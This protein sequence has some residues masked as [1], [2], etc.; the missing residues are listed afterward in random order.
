MLI[1][2]DEIQQYSLELWA[3]KIFLFTNDNI[4]VK[5]QL[6]SLEISF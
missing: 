3:I 4:L 1:K 2:N 6:K 5:N